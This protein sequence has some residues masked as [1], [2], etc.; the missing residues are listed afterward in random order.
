MFETCDCV[1]FQVRLILAQTWRT[2]FKFKGSPEESSELELIEDDVIQFSS[3]V[4][5]D[6]PFSEID[7][8]SEMYFPL[9]YP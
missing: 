4:M 8:K 9:N 5:S 2:D 6:P 7:F 1:I 3:R